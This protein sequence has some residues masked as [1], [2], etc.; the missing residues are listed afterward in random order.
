MLR[1]SLLISLVVGSNFSYLSAKV[2]KDIEK[3][4]LEVI[5]K[6][7]EFISEVLI[8]YAKD[9]QKNDE[10]EKFQKSLEKRY[11]ISIDD[12]PSVGN[13]NA[14]YQL[15]AFVD[16]QCSF[17]KKAEL[18]I[19]KLQEKYGKDILVVY[20][21]YP[22]AFNE[23]AENA[24]KAALAAN[25]QG[26]FSEYKNNLYEN[27]VLLGEHMYLEIAKNLNLDIEK[28]NQDRSSKAIQALINQDSKQAEKLDITGTP[29]FFLNGVKIPGAYPVDYFEKIIGKL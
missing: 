1:L 7:P 10:A 27:Q 18:T 23:E 25:L 12:S 26:K 14:K 11:Q 17:C 24:S 20:K 2:D 21:N 6:N 22:L 5:E 19:S 16:L 13:K 15:I 3:Q 28:F 9:K 4:V 8:N 29:C